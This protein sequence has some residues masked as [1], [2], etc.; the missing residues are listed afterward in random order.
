MKWDDYFNGQL[1]NE[2]QLVTALNAYHYLLGKKY[3]KSNKE[4]E[5]ER[6]VDLCRAKHSSALATRD[7]WEELGIRPVD[8]SAMLKVRLPLEIN[9]WHPDYGFHSVLAVEYEAAAD[10]LRV[11][12]FT[13]GAN[14][15][16]WISI[17]DLLEQAVPHPS[18]KDW[19]FR[20]FVRK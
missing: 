5:Y 13:L 1:Y 7:V 19:K 10:C 17:S 15:D 16:G 18:T 6:L 4:S 9:L 14:W 8:E 3:V 11:T 20:T 2:C 12:N